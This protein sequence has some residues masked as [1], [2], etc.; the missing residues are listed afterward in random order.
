MSIEET[1]RAERD[2][3]TIFI[4]GITEKVTDKILYELFFQA[5]TWILKI[6]CFIAVNK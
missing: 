6:Y 5:G 4:S 3:R 2:D 1:E